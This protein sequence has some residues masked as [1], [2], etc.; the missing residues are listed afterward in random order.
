MGWVD[1][2]F[3]DAGGR[4]ILLQGFSPV[5]IR[6]VMMTAIQVTNPIPQY[7]NISR[8]KA[9]RRKSVSNRIRALPAPIIIVRMTKLKR[10]SNHACAGSTWNLR[11]AFLRES[12]NSSNSSLSLLDNPNINIGSPSCLSEPKS[13]RYYTNFLLNSNSLFSLK[14]VLEWA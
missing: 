11:K 8:A 7:T 13:K 10:N 1:D 3:G 4:F 12:L 5:I 9:G 6:A 14:I 2:Y